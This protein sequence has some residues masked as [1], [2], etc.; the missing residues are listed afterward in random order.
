MCVGKVEMNVGGCRMNVSGVKMRVGAVDSPVVEWRGGDGF[1]GKLIAQSEKLLDR[2]EN[3]VSGDG[4][5]FFTFF[6]QSVERMAA[7]FDDLT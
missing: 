2:I 4:L 3:A 7:F 6:F 5:A 1:A